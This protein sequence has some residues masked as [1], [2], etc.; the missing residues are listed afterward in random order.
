[1][2]LLNNAFK[3]IQH[4]TTSNSTAS[5]DD[6]CQ[7]VYQQLRSSWTSSD[8]IFDTF[9]NLSDSFNDLDKELNNIYTLFQ[10]LDIPLTNIDNDL[11]QQFLTNFFAMSKIATMRHVCQLIIDHSQTF[12]N[13][14]SQITNDGDISTIIVQYLAD[15]LSLAM[16]YLIFSLIPSSQSILENTFIQTDNQ[17][18]DFM[19]STC[20]ITP[21][22]QLA[23]IQQILAQINDIKTSIVDDLT[24]DQNILTISDSTS[25]V[26]IDKMTNREQTNDKQLCLHLVK[27]LQSWLLFEQYEEQI[28]LQRDLIIHAR[29][30]AEKGLEICLL[31]TDIESNFTIVEQAVLEFPPVE[32]LKQ[33][34]LQNLPSLIEQ[35]EHECVKHKRNR[36]K[37]ERELEN[38]RDEKSHLISELKSLLK[39]IPHRALQNYSNIHRE[40]LELCHTVVKHTLHVDTNSSLKYDARI[41]KIKRL[42]TIKTKVFDDLI[43]LNPTIDNENRKRTSS[44]TVNT[45]TQDEV[46]DK[47]TKVTEERNKYAVEICKRIRDK[48]DGSDPDPLTQSSISGQVRYT[49]R[50]ATDIENLATLYEGWT[51]WV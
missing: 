27:I 19:N 18:Q 41:T 20:L 30:F 6:T 36:I 8:E 34:T 28:K 35:A 33:I 42:I 43:Q 38:R 44:S 12:N 51:S 49:V 29:T 2:D 9:L 16:S 7:E 37:E 17:F 21:T 48:L 10:T 26:V 25:T 46:T 40:F 1:M 31:K 15:L 22:N 3:Q 50:E 45:S 14:K 47:T 5:V 23:E 39:I 24:T 4:M 32:N 11:R 13:V